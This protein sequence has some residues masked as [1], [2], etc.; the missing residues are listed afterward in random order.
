MLL[1]AQPLRFGKLHPSP[2]V[3]TGLV[4]IAELDP[5]RLGCC[6]FG[7]G[8][9]RLKFNGV[10]SGVG[11]RINEGMR[12]AQR[13]VMSLSDF[14]DDQTTPPHPGPLPIGWG[15]GGAKWARPDVHP[16][17]SPIKLCLA[18]D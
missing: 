7:G 10:R 16:R 8:N 13:A 2:V 14:G 9:V 11:D 1:K 12:H 6:A 17:N 15:E 18:A 3:V 5:P 4:L